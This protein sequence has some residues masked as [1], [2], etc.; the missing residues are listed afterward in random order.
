MVSKKYKSKINKKHKG[1]V[2]KNA[3]FIKKGEKNEKSKKKD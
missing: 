2:N 1:D 3:T